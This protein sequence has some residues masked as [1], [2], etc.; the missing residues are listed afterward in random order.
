MSVRSHR[1]TPILIA[2]AASAMAVA[3]AA[4]FG[5][6]F[7]EQSQLAAR[8]T[9]RASFLVFLI[10]Y[11]A[12]ALD[13]LFP[14]AVTRRIRQRRRQWGLG[15]ALAHSVH[16][17]AL[18]HAL[19]LTGEQRPL[20]TLI[21]GGLAYALILAMALTSN[22]ASQRALG[23]VWKRLHTIG[24]HYIWFIFFFSYVGRLA[25]PE[26][27]MTGLI[28]APIATAALGLR[29]LAWVKRRRAR[30]MPSAG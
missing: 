18:V 26:R 11:S 20:P 16:L 23:T 24:I 29:I 10:A 21:G 9:A 27:M 1:T 2:F 30:P 14:S 6:D 7:T 13:T 22:D 28:F 15:F 25:D 17:A 4:L 12:S 5:A 8:W 19:T 3:A